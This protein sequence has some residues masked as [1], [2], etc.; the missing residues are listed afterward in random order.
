MTATVVYRLDVTPFT[1]VG[2][3]GCGWRCVAIDPLEAMR[4][5]R[6]HELRAHQGSVAIQQRLIHMEARAGR[7]RQ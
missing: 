6:A 2:V 7:R 4:A 1:V 5:G 3:C